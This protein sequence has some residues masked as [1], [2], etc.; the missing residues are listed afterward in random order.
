M[1]EDMK[2]L[3]E[4][5][6]WKN[7]GDS[8]ILETADATD[9]WRETHYGFT[10]DSGHFLY[11]EVD[12]D[13]D[14]TVTVF[15]DFTSL[16]DQAGLMIRFDEQT[17]LKAGVEY[18]DGALQLSAVITNGASDWSLKPLGAGRDEVTLRLTRQANAIHVQYLE[19]HGLVGQWASL[20][21]GYLQMNGPCQVGLMACSP[22]RGNLHIGFT[23]FSICPSAGIDL[24]PWKPARRNG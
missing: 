15:G 24:H 2:W 12:G 13:F 14:A 10:R 3:N 17:W 16:Y 8:L 6:R 1:F 20:R 22:E 4:P 5:S 18:S 23:D 7:S 11:R 19:R 21:L 9:F